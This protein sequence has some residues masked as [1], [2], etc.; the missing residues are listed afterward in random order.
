MCEYAVLC[1]LVKGIVF[2]TYI[3]SPWEGCKVLW[4]MCPYVCLS[5]RSHISK[6]LV[7]TSLSFVYV[8]PV[9]VSRSLSAVQYHYVLPVLWITCS[10]H[11]CGR[12]SLTTL[13]MVEFT[14]WR[15]HCVHQGRS[16]LSLVAFFSLKQVV[17]DRK[18]SAFIKTL[19]ECLCVVS[20]FLIMCR[21][22]RCQSMMWLVDGVVLPV[23]HI[24]LKPRLGFRYRC[25]L[26]TVVPKG[27]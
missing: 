23:A 3:T 25:C 26:Q 17:G 7:K 1:L 15:P 20:M 12:I 27:L 21:M 22:L 8:L 5:V 16:L 13:C 11:K 19:C 2:C 9:G 10:F 6:I 4:L 14:R 24:L 18:Y